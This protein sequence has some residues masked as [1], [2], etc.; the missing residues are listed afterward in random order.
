MRQLEEDNQELSERIAKTKACISRLR[1]DRVV[2]LSSLSQKLEE[3]QK[4]LLFEMAMDSLAGGLAAFEESLNSAISVSPLF[5]A[6]DSSSDC[7]PTKL[8]VYL[9]RVKNYFNAEAECID[10]LRARVKSLKCQERYL[11]RSSMS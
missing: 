11:V 6:Y 9:E 5:D 2:K 3:T 4:D 8:S 7:V 10:F 1:T